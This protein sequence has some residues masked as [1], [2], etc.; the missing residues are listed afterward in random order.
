MTSKV[1]E[2]LQIN[3]CCNQKHGCQEVCERSQLNDHERNCDYRI[4]NCPD[5]ICKEKITFLDFMDHS[6]CHETDWKKLS[7]F[8]CIGE[9]KFNI[10]VTDYSTTL[11]H[12]FNIKLKL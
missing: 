6:K 10:K 2:I 5:F 8:K 4:I 3:L 9:K 12:I 1:L 7:Q 11:F